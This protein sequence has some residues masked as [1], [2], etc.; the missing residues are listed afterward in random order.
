MGLEPTT[1]S[2]GSWHSTTELLPRSVKSAIQLNPLDFL[3]RGRSIPSML[4]IQNHPFGCQNGQQNIQHASLRIRVATGPQIAIPT[5]SV[6][7]VH[8]AI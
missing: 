2:L 4:S 5:L 6:H 3:N 8:R 7:A 1:S